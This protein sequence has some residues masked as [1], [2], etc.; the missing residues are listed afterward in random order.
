[1]HRLVLFM[2]MCVISWTNGRT[3]FAEIDETA[4]EEKPLKTEEVVV[5]ATKTPL[6][7]SHVT[8]AVE[9]ITEEDLK[10]QHLKTVV[11]ALRL[12]QG[13]AV[14]SN[15]GPGTASSVRMRGGSDTHTLVLIDGAIVNSATLGSFNFANLTTDNIERIEILRGAQSM[16]YGSDAI[17]G[18][19]NIITKRGTG[20]PQVHA[21]FEGGSFGSLR[22][23][24]GASGKKGPVD[25]ALTLS[26]WDLTGFSAADYRLGATERDAYRN[27]TASSK[28]GLTLPHDGRLEFVF[29]WMNSDIRLDNISTPAQDVFGSKTR[30]QAMVFSGSYEQRFT[31]WWSQK[32][33]VARDENQSLFIPGS[34]QRNLLTGAFSVPFGTPNETRVVS[35]RVEVQ[36]N[37]QIFKPLLI[38]AGYQLRDAQGENDTGLTNRIVRSNAGFAEAQLNVWDRVFAA[39]GIRHDSYNVFGDATT[40][41]VTAGYLLKETGTKFRTSYATG[42]RAPTLNQLFFPNFGNPN[43]GPEKSQGFDVGVDQYLLGDRIRMSAGYFWNRYRDLIVTALNEPSC[44]PFSTFLACPINVG[45]AVS[46]GY[47]A[48]LGIII[49]RDHFL[50]KHLEIQGQY[51]NTMTRD[52]SNSVRLPRWPV[53]QWSGLLLYRPIEPVTVALSARYVGSRFNDVQ[54]QQAMKAFDVWSV[55]VSYAITKELQLY[56][57]A[58]NLFNEKYQEILNAGTPVR[59]IYVGLNA[60]YDL[61]WF[62]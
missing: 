24:G 26:R 9:V 47:E 39:A 35:N 34:I 44:A 36:E 56:T 33:T 54:N 8:S 30:E 58:E 11:D 13:L 61:P 12:S 41:R 49:L 45:S 46:K 57:R 42:F 43:L 23:G 59:S 19:I 28:V 37:V 22:E 40:Y 1:M 55:T 3:A 5:T 18:V 32:L 4:T 25:F 31:N 15:G 2:M 62:K 50:I 53:D 48:S 17:G 51:T 60:R 27:W 38:T 6:P 52:E 29:R 21:F 10:Q 16:L 20:T 14:F 7:I